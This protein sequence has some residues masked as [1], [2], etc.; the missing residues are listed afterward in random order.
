MWQCWTDEKL[1]SDDGSCSDRWRDSAVRPLERVDVDDD[2]F[3][4]VVD[5]DDA[6]CWCCCSVPWPCCDCNTQHIHQNNNHLPAMTYEF[7]P[8]VKKI[9]TM[10]VNAVFFTGGSPPR[11]SRCC[12]HQMKRPAGRPITTS[13]RTGNEDVRPRTSEFTLPGGRPKIGIIGTKSSVW[14]HSHR[15]SPSRRTRKAEQ[16]QRGTR[17]SGVCLKAQ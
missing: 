9:M 5:D 1:Y 3:D 12:D 8:R 10:C 13:P 17:N 11:H 4:D 16:T 2:V 14:Q 7:S 6:G 15:S